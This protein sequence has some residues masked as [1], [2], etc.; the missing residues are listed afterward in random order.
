MAALTQEQIIIEGLRELGVAAAG[1]PADPEDLALG[2]TRFNLVVDTWKADRLTI[3]QVLRNTF[4]VGASTA[5]FTIGPGGTWNTPTRPLAIV[6]A[7]FVDTAVSASNPLETP[8]RVYT[9]EE[10]AAV[11]LKTMTSTLSFGLW[12]QTSFDSPLGLGKVFVYPILTRAGTIALYLPVAIDEVA[13][14]ETGLATV[15]L[16]PPGYRKALITSVAIDMADAFGIEPS[17]TLVAKWKAAMKTIKRSNIKPATLR[18][19]ARLTRRA[20]GGG[21]D[22][23]TNE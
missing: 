6:R 2:Q 23:L 11:G 14:D 22:I 20:R 1:E 7:G 10:W 15:I 21:Y 3:Y 19:P 16:V 18:L 17:A 4:V 5:S 9:D 8:I 12:Y 13:D